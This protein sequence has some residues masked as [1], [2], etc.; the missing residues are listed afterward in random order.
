MPVLMSYW[1]QPAEERASWGI[2]DTLVRYSC[3]VEDAD[4]LIADLEHALRAI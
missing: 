2:T 4:D 1:D 3:G